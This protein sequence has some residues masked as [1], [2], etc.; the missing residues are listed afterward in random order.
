MDENDEDIGMILLANQA[1]TLSTT[2]PSKR[3]CAEEVGLDKGFIPIFSPLVK[4][5]LQE[6]GSSKVDV[7]KVKPESLLRD[8][9]TY[10][11][12]VDGATKI[13]PSILG[14]R[15]IIIP[16]TFPSQAHNR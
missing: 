10:Q 5:E 16:P 2:R 14:H 8:P 4:A 7:F 6:E 3:Q 1:E 12:R 9:R 11:Q 13:E 15:Q